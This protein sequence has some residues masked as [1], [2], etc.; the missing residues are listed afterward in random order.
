MFLSSYNNSS[1]STKNNKNHFTMTKL[2]QFVVITFFFLQS[3]VFSATNMLVSGSQIPDSVTS[4]IDLTLL[5]QMGLVGWYDGLSVITETHQ[6]TIIPP[7]TSSGLLYK[8]STFFTMLANTSVNGTI[9]TSCRRGNDLFIAGQFQS[10]NQQQ[11]VWNIAKLTFTDNNVNNDDTMVTVTTLG[12]GLDGPVYTMYCDIDRIYVG[13]DFLAPIQSSPGYGDSLSSFGGK[14]AMW[15]ISNGSWAALPWKGVNGPIYSIDKFKNQVYFAGQFDST[16]DGQMNHAPASQPIDLNSPTTTLETHNSDP[17]YNDAHGLICSPGDEHPWLLEDNTPGYWQA[18]FI[19]SVTPSLFRLNNT[20]YEGRGTKEFGIRSL[21]NNHFFNMTYLDPITG[22]RLFCTNNCTLSDD[23]SIQFQEFLVINNPSITFGIR[24]EITSWYGLGGGLSSVEIYQSE[25][26]VHA[27][28]AGNFPDCSSSEKQH[29]PTSSASTNGKWAKAQAGHYM[30]SSIPIDQIKTST[31]SVTFTPYLIEPGNYTVTLYTPGCTNNKDAPCQQRTKVDVKIYWNNST[32]PR[33]VTIDQ[34]SPKD[35]IDKIYTGPISITAESFKPRVEISISKS[36]TLP[37]KSSGNVIVVANA[38]QWVKLASL[39][40][41]S[42]VLVYNPQ[43]ASSPKN[44]TTTALSWSPLSPS[45]PMNTRINAMESVNNDLY[46]AGNFSFVEGNM[47]YSN[48]VKLDGKSGQ[49]GS[50]HGGGL[51]G[52]VAS[53]THYQSD[54]Y[55]GGTFNGLTNQFVSPSSPISKNVVRYNTQR[56]EWLNLDGGVD[57]PVSSVLLTD[58]QT[59]ILVSGDYRGLYNASM[60]NISSGNTW[61]NPSINTWAPVDTKPYLTGTIYASGGGDFGQQY[62]LGSIKSAQRYAAPQGFVYMNN[63]QIHH[64]PLNPLP[65]TDGHG[66]ITAGA[67]WNDPQHGNASTIILGGSFSAGMGIRNVALYQQGQ[68]QGIGAEDWQGSINTMMV[69]GN[70]LFIGGAFST[71]MKQ[72]VPGLNSFAIYDL[73]NRTFVHVPDLHTGDGSPTLVNMIKYSDADGMVI[74]GGNFSTGGSLSCY[75]VCA[76]DMT[77]Y[78]WNNLGDG[79]LG[80]VTDFVFIDNKLM[81]AGNLTL[82]NGT[83]VPVAAYDYGGNNWEP[84]S[85]SANENGLPGPCHAVSYDNSTRTTFFAGQQSNTSTAYI[86]MWNGQQFSSPNQELGPGSTIQQLSVLPTVTNTT[87]NL[88]GNTKAVL[89]ATG[90]LNLGQQNVSA[91]LYNGTTWIPYLVASTA[92]GTPGLFSRVFFKSYS[93]SV[94][95]R[96]YMAV[97]F[98]ILVSIGSALGVTFLLILASLIVLGVKRRQD[99]KVD[100]AQ[101]WTYSGKPP[102]APDTLLDMLSTGTLTTT[103][104]YALTGGSDNDDHNNN[105]NEKNIPLD[106]NEDGSAIG[107]G[108]AL[109][110]RMMAIN[111][112]YPPVNNEKSLSPPVAAYLSNP[113]GAYD[114]NS[115]MM[116]MM[117]T[118]TNREMSSTPSTNPFRVSSPMIGMA[119]TDS[120]PTQQQQ[121]NDEVVQGDVRSTTTDV[122]MDPYRFSELIPPPQ[123]HESTI[124]TMPV[125]SL[126]QVERLTH[127]SMH[128]PNDSSSPFGDNTQHPVTWTHTVPDRGEAMVTNATDST[129]FSIPPTSNH[130]AAMAKGA[131]LSSIPSSPSYVS[132]IEQPR[133]ITTTGRTSSP[134]STYTSALNYESINNPPLITSN[135]HHHPEEEEEIRIRWTQFNSEG[136]QDRLQISNATPS[137]HSEYSLGD[138][139]SNNSSSTFPST[140]FGLGT[141]DGFSSDPDIAR[142]TTTNDNNQQQATIPPPLPS[143]SSLSSLSNNDDKSS[144]MER[145][146]YTSGLRFSSV[147]LPD[148]ITFPQQQQSTTTLSSDGDMSS[149]RSSVSS[150]ASSHHQPQQS[151]SLDLTSSNNV[152]Q[153]INKN[154]NATTNKGQPV[155]S[156]ET[157][158]TSA[159]ESRWSDFVASTSSPIKTTTEDLLFPPTTQQQ[160]PSPTTNTDSTTLLSTSPPAEVMARSTSSASS[161]NPLEG[162]AASKKMIQD[163][164]S[165]RDPTTS[166]SRQQKYKSDFK[167][168][169]QTALQNNSNTTGKCSQ[170]HPYLYIAKFDFSAREHGELGFEKGDPIIVIDAEDDIWWMGYKN[171]QDDVLQGV[172][173]SNYV[174]R[175]TF[176]PN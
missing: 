133:A 116:M 159:S 46:L 48:V 170:D 77:E 175:A 62:Y 43:Q 19:Y 17:N 2:A 173:P 39:P 78:Q 87:S 155:P 42:S 36:V 66:I 93:M 71:I 10:L 25:I 148:D 151:S 65:S 140:P 4:M 89:L 69:V 61:W 96:R 5:E 29:L 121:I 127:N 162:R 84:I 47:S 150:L 107:A 14:M 75:G 100:C 152:T 21:S 156:L 125:M 16:T 130:T 57:G 63:N 56:Q 7:H 166:A 35:R 70:R 51:D 160:E 137:M 97:P 141:Y 161:V 73:V 154:N 131:R 60:I 74:V 167:R 27:D 115:N 122:N 126:A 88:S 132:S 72:D 119:I 11:K 28:K 112:N 164:L 108:V 157:F 83:P 98:V 67:F 76:L 111:N 13:G 6:L 124:L 82:T 145:N 153:N 118:T 142:W 24:I 85:D 55:L 171:G 109:G 23:P 92:D 134:F 37:Q 3:Y 52:P 163:Y 113:V 20:H 99:A 128:W 147:M 176:L 40:N 33:V 90:F 59:N 22:N 15:M 30:V 8:N 139:L 174:E 123:Q 114:N 91:A 120:P 41:L 81:V 64:H 117:A 110:A 138:Y 102:M 158:E 149:R 136:A 12:N 105:N 32:S 86:R 135:D 95:N 101:P 53:L 104:L 129:L 54:L 80:N 49:L 144:S 50:L 26:F 68:W 34:N 169:M 168:A 146:T 106:T 9:T 44:T 31:N 165:S 172:F 58:N 1:R 94:H 38:V 79:I 143:S 103:G 18:A 45:L